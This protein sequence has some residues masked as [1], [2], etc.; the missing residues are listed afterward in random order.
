MSTKIV[1]TGGVPLRGEVFVSG[2]KNAALPIIFATVL[3]KDD[4]VLHNIPNVKDIAVSLQILEQMGA[5]VTHLSPSSVR[6]NTHDLRP[7]TAPYDLVQKL[8]GSTYLLGAELGAYQKASVGW[9]GGCDFGTRPLDQHFKGFEALGATVSPDGGYIELQAENGL[10]GNQIYFDVASVGAT[11]NIMLAAVCAKGTTVIGNAAREPHI[12]DLA[13]FLNSCGANITG[14]GTPIIKVHGVEELHGTEYTI[15]PDMIEAGTYMVAAAITRG[16]VYVRSVIPKHVEAVTAKLCEMGVCVE[17]E[18][19][20]LYVHAERDSVL[21]NINIKT[22]PYPGFPT[23]MHPQFA[24]MLCLADGISCIQ[25]S[26]WDNRFRYI[27]ELR[28]MGANV[29]LNSRTATFI[30]VERLTGA[31]VSA[32]DLR[33]GAALVIAGLAADGRTE[34]GGVKYIRRGYENL[35]G[36]FQSLGAHIEEVEEED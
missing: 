17:E 30:G 8:R 35:V 6:I 24:P 12:V 14:A 2:M 13:N 34:I 11:V 33:A 36:K 9:P 22:L 16:E 27:A 26:I 15:I 4:C 25:E 3:V 10:L 29:M 23:D 19:D 21:K 32:T 20:S 7:G 5:T 28:K 18:E 1:I 31:P